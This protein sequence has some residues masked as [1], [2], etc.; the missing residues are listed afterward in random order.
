MSVFTGFKRD[1]QRQTHRDAVGVRV[2]DE[3]EGGEGYKRWRLRADLVDKHQVE[4]P[5]CKS[6]RAILSTVVKPNDV[7]RS[8]G[9]AE[10]KGLNDDEFVKNEWGYSH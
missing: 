2:E 5:V 3:N 6:C 10:H 8:R 4:H 7:K 9:D 1:R